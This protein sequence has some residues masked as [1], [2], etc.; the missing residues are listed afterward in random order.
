MAF[1][2]SLDITGSALTAER[3]RTDI[4]LQNIANARTTRTA[5]GG[6]YRRKQVVFEER[7]LPLSFQEYYRHA[8]KI[9]GSRRQT[10]SG[11]VKVQQ[12][13]DS[14]NEFKPVYDPHH[15][16]ADADGYVWYPNVDTTE[17]MTDLMAATNAYE[18]NLTALGVVKAM[19]SKSLDIA[20]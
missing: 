1:L 18:A 4:I 6:P 16:D 5:A 20:K 17:E 2:R 10:G 8:C 12:M 19:I 9:G 15:P 3:Y 7:P 14:I 11:G 13:V